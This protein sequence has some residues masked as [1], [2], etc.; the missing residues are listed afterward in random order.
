M[1]KN[2]EHHQIIV[3]YRPLVMNQ[4]IHT[5]YFSA[6]PE[7][8]SGV[9]VMAYTLAYPN[10]VNI[11]RRDGTPI[12]LN[13]TPKTLYWGHYPERS[14]YTAKFLNKPVSFNSLDFIQ[15]A[16]Q[17]CLLFAFDPSSTITEL[18]YQYTPTQL[19]FGRYFASI[20]LSNPTD[21]P[22]GIP[23]EFDFLTDILGESRIESMSR[24]LRECFPDSEQGTIVP[25]ELYFVTTDPEHN[26]VIALAEI[27]SY[28]PEEI[29]QYVGAWYIFNVCT[30]NSV[31]GQGLSKSIMV[32]MLNNLYRQGVTQFILEVLP[33]NTVAYNLYTSLGFRKVDSVTEGDK[34]YDVLLLP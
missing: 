10:S 16:I 28:L 21:Y 11:T 34:T 6:N 29:E 22:D 5:R 18:K 14:N 31:R 19:N 8:L 1:D 24:N 32:A 2:P 23:I 27:T 17:V 33:S 30:S 12:D 25:S 20:S 7:Q 3:Q 13:Q 4:T 26:E 15:G 9:L